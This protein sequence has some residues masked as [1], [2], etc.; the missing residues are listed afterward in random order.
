M[1]G[2]W[3][4]THLFLYE[5]LSQVLEPRW[6]SANQGFEEARVLAEVSL[7]PQN[8]RVGTGRRPVAIAAGEVKRV[9]KGTE[10]RKKVIVVVTAGWAIMCFDHNL[11][12]LWE[13]DVQVGSCLQNSWW[14]TSMCFVSALETKFRTSLLSD[15]HLGSWKLHVAI[16][17]WVSPWVSSQRSGNIN[18]QLYTKAWW[19]RPHHCGRQY[20]SPTSGIWLTIQFKVMH[21]VW[22]RVKS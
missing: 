12:K 10:R 2:C 13:D 9:Y 3:K 20:G 5:S 6:T 17:G 7:L 15:R 11:K 22:L 8:V 18:K 14:R 16:A 4:V 1:V 19:H 21:R